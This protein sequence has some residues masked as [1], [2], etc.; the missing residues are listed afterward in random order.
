MRPVVDDDFV[1]GV[2]GGRSGGSGRDFG[3]SGGGGNFMFGGGDVRSAIDED[4]VIGVPLH[5][6]QNVLDEPEERL[7]EDDARGDVG[8]PGGSADRGAREHDKGGDKSGLT[9]DVEEAVSKA[10][11]LAQRVIREKAKP[12]RHIAWR[13]RE[14]FTFRF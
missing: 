13:G 7:W 5:N 11:A 4:F 2:S 10:A 3:A 8:G 6:Q 12:Q 1:A 14:R 9:G